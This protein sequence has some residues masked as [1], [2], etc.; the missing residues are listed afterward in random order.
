MAAGLLLLQSAHVHRTPLIAHCVAAA[1]RLAATSDIKLDA[2]IL[3][4]DPK[5]VS[6]TK[7]AFPSSVG[8]VVAAASTRRH[9]ELLPSTCA[10]FLLPLLE[11]YSFVVGPACSTIH[12]VLARVGAAIGSQPVT[13]V[14]RILGPYTF[15]RLMYAGAVQATVRLREP[16]ATRLVSLR[17]SS[18]QREGIQAVSIATV[19]E[20]EERDLDAYWTEADGTVL[21]PAA[22]EPSG[23]AGV[24][25]ETASIVIGGG[26]GLGTKENFDRLIRPLAAKLH[27]AVGATMAAVDAG[28]APV[29]TQIGQTGH[30]IAPEVYIAAGISGAPQHLAGLADAGT[31]IAIN[32]DAN[33]PIFK[34]CDYGMVGD[35]FKILPELTQRLAPSE[36]AAP[37]K[38]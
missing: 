11:R 29:E 10:R 30:T 6:S 12:S 35:V 32:S 20:V 36:N 34:R 13:D 26:R 16:V 37:S 23:A 33:A 18:V 19:P 25:I 5:T 15:T 24:D 38:F 21:L 4:A 7:N 22:A 8:H 28:I 31:I 2:L 9:A 14:D 3:A 1:Q 27:A 17:P